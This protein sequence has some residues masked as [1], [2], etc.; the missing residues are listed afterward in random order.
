MGTERG[1]HRSVAITGGG[2]GLGRSVALKLAWRNFP[3]QCT[4][5]HR[6]APRP[7]TRCPLRRVKVAAH[8][9]AVPSLLRTASGRMIGVEA[10]LGPRREVSMS[11]NDD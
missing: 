9:C 4:S 7:N 10:F 3:G 6:E 11:W 1:A 2:R 8:T 5:A